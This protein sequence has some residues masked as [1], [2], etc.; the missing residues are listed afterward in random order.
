MT[1]IQEANKSADQADLTHLAPAPEALKKILRRHQKE[2]G[3]LIPVL[4]DIQKQFGYIP[5]ELMACVARELRRPMSE[6]F[7]VASFY[8]QFSLEPKGKN[9][10][11][12]CLGTACHVRGGQKI[13]EAFAQTLGIRAGETTPDKKFS[14]ERVACLGACGLAPVVMINQ[15]TYGRLT[16]ESV[17]E[18]LKEGEKV[19]KLH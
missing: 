15:S 7:G 9:L 16:P 4:Q 17:P 14:L 3:S 2:E 1:P 5:K 13:L 10:I 8:A 18:I 6:V 12:V 19:E 11:R